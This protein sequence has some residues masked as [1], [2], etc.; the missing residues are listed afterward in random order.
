MKVFHTPVI[1][2]ININSQDIIT[3]SICS[4][5]TCYGHQCPDCPW[6]DGP[7]ECIAYTCRSY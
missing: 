7:G 5:N 3:T 4:T 1:E 6:C 2:I